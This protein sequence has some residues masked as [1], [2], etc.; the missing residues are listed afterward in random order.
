MYWGIMACWWGYDHKIV[1]FNTQVWPIVLSLCARL[2]DHFVAP[3]TKVKKKVGTANGMQTCWEGKTDSVCEGGV[4]N[5][6]QQ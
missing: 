6:P 3:Y 2:F 4:A 1:G 5:P